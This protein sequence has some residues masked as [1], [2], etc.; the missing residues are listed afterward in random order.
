MQ[1]EGYHCVGETCERQCSTGG[2]ECVAVEEVTEAFT[3]C[4]DAF[5]WAKATHV[6][7]PAGDVSTQV[8]LLLAVMYVYISFQAQ[9]QRRQQNS[10]EN[11]C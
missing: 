3:D 10:T 6:C 9:W 5:Q 2:D 4:D 11:S 8:R 7:I 1:G